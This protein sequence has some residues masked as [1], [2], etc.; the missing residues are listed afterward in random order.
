MEDVYNLIANISGEYPLAQAVSISRITC[1][2]C[3][4]DSHQREEIYILW[5]TLPDSTTLSGTWQTST[6][7][8]F[9][10]MMW[11]TYS[12]WTLFSYY[13][14]KANT[15]RKWPVWWLHRRTMYRHIKKQ[16]REL[17]VLPT[18]HIKNENL[19]KQ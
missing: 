3:F 16:V 14:G 4:R 10:R 5:K 7:N 2:R 15:G 19:T 12:K 13:S 17:H 8:W 18:C 6:I 1:A 11:Q 9:T